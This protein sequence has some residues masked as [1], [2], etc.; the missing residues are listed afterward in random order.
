MEHP[1]D[2]QAQ[3]LKFYGVAILFKKGIETEPL[4]ITKEKED[5]ILSLS[6]LFEKQIFQITNIHAPT[7]PSS[8]IKF[9]K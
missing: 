2:T 9:Y 3:K 4:N 7:N 6:F 1:I 5:K 8:R